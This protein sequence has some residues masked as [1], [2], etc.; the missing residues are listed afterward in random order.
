MLK[1]KQIFIK[2]LDFLI[3]TPD[4]L[5]SP[6]IELAELNITKLSKKFSLMS[7]SVTFAP[8]PMNINHA[9]ISD[10]SPHIFKKIGINRRKGRGHIPL[11]CIEP[12]FTKDYIIILQRSF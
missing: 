1:Y 7:I 11:K 12:R 2:A 4:A 9:F 10:K 3:G 6:D 5:Q 8:F